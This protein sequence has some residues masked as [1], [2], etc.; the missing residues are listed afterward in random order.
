MEYDEEALV[1]RA[2]TAYFKAGEMDQPSSGGDVEVIDG[3]PHVILRN[4][5]GILAVYSYNGTSLKRVEEWP[6]QLS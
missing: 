5:K 6:D 1:E 4:I 3:V 2:R